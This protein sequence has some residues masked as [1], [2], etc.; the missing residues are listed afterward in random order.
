[1]SEAEM[2]A[3]TIRGLREEAL[4]DGRESKG[5]VGE[6]WQCLRGSQCHLCVESNGLVHAV[7]SMV[8]H[9]T[10]I[11]CFDSKRLIGALFSA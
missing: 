7:Q 8:D 5:L 1:M 9:L 3:H 10:G 11:C 6:N 4:A 2:D